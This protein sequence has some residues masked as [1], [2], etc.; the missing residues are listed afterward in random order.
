MLFNF[1]ISE[2]NILDDF[3]NNVIYVNLKYDFLIGFRSMLNICYCCMVEKYSTW[4]GDKIY[5]QNRI[6][7]TFDT[8]RARYTDGVHLSYFPDDFLYL[9]ESDIHYWIVYLSKD[10]TDSFMCKFLKT[11]YSYKETISEIQKYIISHKNTTTMLTGNYLDMS[12]KLPNKT[13]L[14]EF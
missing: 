13:N 3:K 12:V 10:S 8:I 6:S 4:N 11:K 7:D 9:G 1:K 2:K 5:T 14:Q